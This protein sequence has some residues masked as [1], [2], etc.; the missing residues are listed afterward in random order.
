MSLLQRFAYNKSDTPEIRAEKLAIFIVAASCTIL[1]SIWA[2][3]YYIIFGFKIVTILPFSYTVIVGTSL[4]ISHIVKN[5]KPATYAQITCIIFITTLISKP[6]TKKTLILE[7]RY[8]C[9]QDLVR[10]M[11]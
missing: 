2:L 11:R 3:M 9:N 1:G 4:V 8:R 6:A 7:W 10:V 5:H